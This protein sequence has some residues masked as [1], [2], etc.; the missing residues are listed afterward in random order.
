MVLVECPSTV[1][2]TVEP[3]IPQKT[4]ISHAEAVIL[5][6]HE[7]TKEARNMYCIQLRDFEALVERRQLPQETQIGLV[8]QLVLDPEADVFYFEDQGFDAS[9]FR[10]IVGYRRPPANLQEHLISDTFAMT[11]DLGI[12]VGD[13]PEHLKLLP[14]GK[15]IAVL[16]SHN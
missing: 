15:P 10:K 13:S 9:R 6:R 7:L 3:E 1:T 11:T 14:E 4:D 2:A 12:L 16:V 8:G 5:S